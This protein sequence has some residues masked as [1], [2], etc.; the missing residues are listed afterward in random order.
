MQ[1]TFLGH[2]GCLVE[3]AHGS[4]LCDPW[5]TPAY[6]ASW[7]PFPRND[8]LVPALVE[9]LRTVD[10]LYLSHLHRDHF[11]PAWLGAHVGRQAR[12]LLP[13]FGID[14]MARELG[15]LGFHDLVRTKHGER[16]DLD[17]LGVTILAM[18]T[19]ADGPLGDSAVIL[20]DGATRLLNQNDARPGDLDALHD[21]GPFDAQ[22]LQFSGAIWYPIAYDFP[23]AEKERLARV[24]R[25]DEM[26]R[27]ERYIAAVGATHVFPCAGPPCFLDPELYAFNDLDRDP[28]NIFPDQT[29]FLDQLAEHG[30]NRAH[31]IVPGS[32][33]AIEGD[34]CTVT[35]PSHDA[36]TAPFADKAGYLERYRRD[37]AERLATEKQSWPRPG[38]DLVAELATWFEPLLESAPITSAGVAGNVVLD[39]GA[40]ESDVCIDFVESTVRGWKGEPYVYKLDVDRALL[41]TLVDDHVEDW[42][43]SLL[44]S[45]R[46]TAHRAGPFN[47]FVLTFFK[48]LSPERMAYVEQCLGAVRRRTDEFFEKDGWRIERWCPHR[49]ADLKRFGDIDDGVLTC[50]LHHWRFDLATGRCL[51]SD[52]RHLRCERVAPE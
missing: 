51:T 6:F 15:A 43:N 40:A 47:E 28:A 27:A 9:R 17:G 20:D 24:K 16:I 52:D 37:W 42:V 41:E 3:T 4:V 22:L 31:L 33:V 1:I 13:D 8:D 44:L 36:A 49:Q 29:V 45:C 32:V 23:P 5:F 10:Y 48:A 19:P 30:V 21:L 18:T 26:E 46:F 11:D 25:V 39:T 14:L 38:H 34:A 50:S 35:H 2:A 7:F 12:V